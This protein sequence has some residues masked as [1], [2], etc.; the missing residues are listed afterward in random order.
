M[1]A[2]VTKKEVAKQAGN[3]GKQMGTDGVKTLW[4]NKPTIPTLKQMIFGGAY[5]L[6]TNQYFPINWGD[7]HS[8]GGTATTIQT[9]SYFSIAGTLKN[10]RGNGDSG[11]ST[12]LTVYKNGSATDLSITITSG[13]ATI[14]N[15]HTVSIA[16]G[17]YV[18]ILS[19]QNFSGVFSFEFDPS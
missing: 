19:T 14:D 8:A 15:T 11:F 1:G 16:A 10:F 4:E 17:D 5:V 2:K 6:A 9:R 7:S 3:S 18:N 12:T 13:A